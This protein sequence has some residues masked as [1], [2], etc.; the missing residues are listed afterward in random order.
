MV[1]FA[2]IDTGDVYTCGNGLNGRLGH[3]DHQNKILPTIVLR[4]KQRSV[5]SVC[6][7]GEAMLCLTRKPPLGSPYVE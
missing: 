5:H 1:I 3:P 6:D 4:L 2:W 7:T